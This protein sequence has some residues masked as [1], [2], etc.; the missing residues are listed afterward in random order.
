M[1]CGVMYAISDCI[2]GQ[3][4]YIP[5]DISG[6]TRDMR[7]YLLLDI[8]MFHNSPLHLQTPLSVPWSLVLGP[9]HI[10]SW[11][12]NRIHSSW[13]AMLQCRN[14]VIFWTVN[15]MSIWEFCLYHMQVMDGCCLM[16]DVRLERHCRIKWTSWPVGSGVPR[17]PKNIGIHV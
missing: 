14:K 7:M 2:L 8:S 6:S 12:L 3:A 11:P 9:L 13:R 4:H 16:R 1:L 15:F 5:Y 10:Y 17:R